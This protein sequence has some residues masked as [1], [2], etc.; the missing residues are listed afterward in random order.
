LLRLG[1]ASTSGCDI[2]LL[3]WLKVVMTTS[4]QWQASFLSNWVNGL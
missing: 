2:A 4:F 1:S 3:R